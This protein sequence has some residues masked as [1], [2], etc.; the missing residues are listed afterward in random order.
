MK[1]LLL[2]FLVFTSTSAIAADFRNADWGMSIEDVKKT[3][4]GEIIR[5]SKDKIT[6]V[7]TV[8]NY[9]ALVV[10][11]FNDDQLI[12]GSYGFKQ[13][14]DSDDEYLEDFINFNTVISNKYGE[15]TVHDRW[16]NKDS[17]FKDNPAAAV[18]EGDLVMWRSWET[19][20]TVIKLIMYGYGGKFNLDTYYFSKKYGDKTSGIYADILKDRF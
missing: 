2:L 6:Y 8:V 17:E 10:F 16:T 13:V 20:S 19:P 14:N 12:W 5:E 9:P 7:E 4:K 18:R 15:G 1:Y 11:Q 3:E